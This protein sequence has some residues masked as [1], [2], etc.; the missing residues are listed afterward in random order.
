MDGRTAAKPA[1][2]TYVFRP[3]R[4]VVGA[5]LLA[6]GAGSRMGHK[7]KCLLELGGKPLIRRLLAALSGAG[8]DQLV[9]VL[10]H[11]ADRIEPVVRDFP[12]TLVRNP[13]PDAGQNTSLRLGLHALSGKID[14]VLVA[15]ADQPLIN[16]Q[17]IHDL[18]GAYTQRPA[19][20][21]VVQPA[22]DG[23]PG[24]PVMFS[25]MVRQ[26]ILASE[27]HVGCKQWQAANPQAVH[28]WVSTNPHYRIDVD[29][30][31]DVEALAARTG[32]QLRWP[33]D[34]RPS[35]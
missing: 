32:H 27:A 33:A 10:G 13:E 31:E 18:I 22:V 4:P 21:E 26:H 9:V 24:N 23:L 20:T 3:E 28:P 34:L 16:T 30:L 11:H 15:L 8:V 17:D 25:Q 35:A 19:G 2:G 5:V 12:V 1:Q 14:S 29:S 7:P 6:A